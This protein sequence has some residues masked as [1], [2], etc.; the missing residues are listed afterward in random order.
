MVK[1]KAGWSVP[2]HWHTH[3]EQLLVIKGATTI[4]AEG[5]QDVVLKP[6][7]YLFIP[8]RLV[9]RGGCPEDCVQYLYVEGPD[10]FIDVKTQ[11][12]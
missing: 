10:S 9:H 1:A 7:D 12:P 6:G 8:A 5:G 11:R 3:D 4:A 2:L